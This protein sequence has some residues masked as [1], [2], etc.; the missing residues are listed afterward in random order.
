MKLVSGLSFHYLAN[1]S[2]CPRYPYTFSAEKVRENDL[3]FLNLDNFN[4]F[5]SILNATPPR[6]KFVLVTHNSDKAF[7]ND[8][9]NR[10]STYVS[11]VYAINNLCNYRQVKT[12]PIGF[13]DSSL[14]IIQKSKMRG[15]VRKDILLYMNFTLHTNKIKRTECLSSFYETEGY[16]SRLQHGAAPR[17]LVRNRLQ[18]WVVRDDKVDREIFYANLARAR[19]VLC[20]EGTGIDCHRTY[21][22]MYFD[23]VPVMKSGRMDNFFKDL[24]VIIVSDWRAITKE[25]LLDNYPEYLSR[26]S[27]WKSANPDW[28]YPMYWMNR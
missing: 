7:T 19:Y 5:V 10:I 21:E 12:I 17:M 6:H 24:P 20:P 4:Q 3:I 26:L 23:T 11:K 15:M 9:F 2:Y 8:H 14:P 16:M 28:V 1:L 27:K 22:A 18:D 25:R 13:Q